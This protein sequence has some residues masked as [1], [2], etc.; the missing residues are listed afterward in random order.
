MRR[1]ATIDE[2]EIARWKERLGDRVF[3]GKLREFQDRIFKIFVR[4]QHR[5]GDSLIRFVCPRPDVKSLKSVVDKIRRNRKT[6]SEG[7]RPYNFEDVEDLVGIKVLCPYH[8]SAKEV[9]NWMFTQSHFTVT[10]TSI[11][12]AWTFNKYG[13]RGWHFVAEPSPLLLK[14]EPTFMGTKCEIQVKTMLQEAWDAQTHD[15]S[16]KKEELIDT[17]LLD[18]IKSQSNILAALDEQSE[19]IRKLIQ[20]VEEEEREHMNI[21]ATNYLYLLMGT[22]FLDYLKD[23]Y[24][25]ELPNYN[26]DCP[27]SQ[28]RLKKVNGVIGSYRKAKG[29]NK[30]LIR[31][32]AFIALCQRNAEQEE[33]TFSLAQDF[34]NANPEDPEAEDVL[35]GVYWAL[36]RVDEAIKHGEKAINKAR[37]LKIDLTL[38]QD[39]FCYWVT[40]AV[41]ARMDVEEKLKKLVLD[42]T[43]QFSRA[44]P[45]DPKYQ[46]TAAFVK[47][48]LGTTIEEIESGLNLTREARKLAEQSNDEKTQ[49]LACAFCKRH[50]RLAFFKINQIYQCNKP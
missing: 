43:E 26:E 49:K 28:D 35:A 46:D 19:I 20:H 10:P 32:A 37:N 8:S 40:E 16:Y 9:M 18:H 27:L 24:D 21:A 29:L 48:V 2:N 33:M 13:Y 1:D 30:N 45:D 50:E 41:R 5:T 4:H 17:E 31:F 12:D 38:Y 11:E 44:H 25:I 15:L 3:A 22:E 7:K 34:V 47:I 36:Y 14:L 23:S 6:Q 39:N 42:L